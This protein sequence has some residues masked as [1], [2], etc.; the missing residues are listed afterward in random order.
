MENG[1]GRWVER[2]SKRK[3]DS[4]L[5]ITLGERFRMPCEVGHMKSYFWFD[6]RRL[7]SRTFCRTH[8]RS[9]CKETHTTT[10]LYRLHTAPQEGGGHPDGTVPPDGL[11]GHHW[12]LDFTGK[13]KSVCL[14][15]REHHTGMLP[16]DHTSLWGSLVRGLPSTASG[17]HC[18][19]RREPPI[20][21]WS[22]TLSV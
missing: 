8:P 15:E 5:N 4:F 1:G 12:H 18:G 13:F 14:R 11:R 7:C 22:R 19:G 16:T 17:W 3:L 9:P 6:S 21:I 20:S 2:G 10:Y